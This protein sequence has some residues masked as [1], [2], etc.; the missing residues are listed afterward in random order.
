[1]ATATIERSGD[2][3]GTSSVDPFA[4][5]LNTMGAAFDG[6]LTGRQAKV[7]TEKITAR[8]EQV[9]AALAEAGRA[10]RLGPLLNAPDPGQAWLDADI[11]IRRAVLDTLAIVTVLPGTLGRAPFDPASVKLRWKERE[12]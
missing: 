6:L 1:M 8:L 11:D 7:A 9:E 3:G 2:G 5:C 12:A 10:T 4:A